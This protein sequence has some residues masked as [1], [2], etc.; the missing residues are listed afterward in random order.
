MRRVPLERLVRYR[1]GDG[2]FF[3]QGGFKCEVQHLLG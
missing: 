1:F 2:H 3:K